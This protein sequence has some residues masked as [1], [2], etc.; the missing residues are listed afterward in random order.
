MAPSN[1]NTYEETLELMFSLM[2]E[3]TSTTLLEN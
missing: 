3:T 2:D 1:H